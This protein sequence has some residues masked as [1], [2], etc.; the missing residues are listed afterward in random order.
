MVNRLTARA[1]AAGVAVSSASADETVLR[2]AVLLQAGI[3]PARAWSHLAD[4]GDAGAARVT[5]A[6]GRGIPLSDA[7]L[8]AAPPSPPRSRRRRAQSRSTWPEV[9]AAWR[10][11]TTVGAPLA[12]SLRGLAAAL[13]DAAEAVDDVRVALAE[14]AGTARLIGWLPL[15]GLALGACL[16]FDTM[17]VLLGTPVGLLCLLGGVALS[18][19]AHRWNAV[20]VRRATA[21]DG[22]PGLDAELLAIAVS[23]GV[24]LDRA[25]AI[26]EQATE[27]GVDAESA[28]VLS[29]SRTAGAPAVD[30]LRASAALARQRARIDGRLRA[31]RLSSRLLLPLGVCTLPA[32]LLLGVAPMLLSVMATM[33]LSL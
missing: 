10:V 31:S 32:F 4:A 8:E 12:E 18:V 9:A 2:L 33:S 14:P 15:V 22:I 29:L 16:G 23:G 26:V 11:A 17:G 27:R 7:I 6:V 28:A 25:T 3:P 5:D 1:A 21:A 19:A 13:R 30:L 24:S 20:L